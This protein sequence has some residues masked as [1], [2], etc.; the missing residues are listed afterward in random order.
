MTE[1]KH[2]LGPSVRKTYHCQGCYALQTK[3]W[4]FVEENDG[5]DSGTDAECS[6]MTPTKH[7]ASYW[8]PSDKAPEWCPV[9]AELNSKAG[10][11][12]P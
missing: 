8:R 10:G 2:T 1:S 6:A 4:S 5:W 3:A 9:L 12:H 7:I 11:R